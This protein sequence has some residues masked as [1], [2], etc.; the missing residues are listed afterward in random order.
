MSKLFVKTYGCTLNKKD[1]E[2]VVKEHYFTEDFAEIKKSDYILINTC[3]VKEQT[4]TK[5]LNFLKK[6]K[7]NKIPQEKIIIF[8]CL[9]DIDKEALVKEMP[10]AKYFKVSEK[11]KIEVIINNVGN[12]K[13]NLKK[14]TDTIIISNGCLG[15]CYYCA[16][17]FAR[18][19]LE[20]KPIEK[21][22]KEIEYSV[23]EENSKEILLTSQDNGCYGFD[24]NENLNTL[25]KR[26]I[27]IK[28]DFKIRVGMANP[29]HLKIIIDD[30][31]KIYKNEKIY[32]FLHIPIQSG[33]NKVLKEMN[34][35]YTIEDVYTII[36]KFKK[37]IPEIS[38]GTDIIVGYPTETEEDFKETIKVIKKIKPNFINLSRFG[39][40]KNIEAEKYKDLISRT[41][42][43]RSREITKIF[44]KYILEKNKLEIGK[45]KEIIITEIGKNNKFVG[46]TNNYLSVVIDENAKIG[47]KLK[48]KIIDADKY[49]LKGKIL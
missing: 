22:I 16:V 17:K 49:Y 40:R 38:I 21:I 34:R 5:I 12:N 25:L 18:G 6:L 4:Q 1:T 36:D 42:K 7:E 23:N 39:M 3:G 19:R 46:K 13:K 15:N 26:I 33:S 2:N 31:I 37:E 11:E 30:L 24:I 14:N 29:Q 9:V 10:D 44:E 35:Y 20:S 27:E 48:V 32:K 43:E 41:K 28:G 45:E 8:G 47:Q